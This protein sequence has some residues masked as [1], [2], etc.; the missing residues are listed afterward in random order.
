[1]LRY[2]SLF[3]SS[4]GNSTYIGT[5]NG[6]ILIDAGVSA[7]RIDAALRERSIDPS[8]IRA[9]L[10]SHEHSDHVSGVAVLAKRYGWPILASEG[11]LEALVQTDKLSPQHRLFMVQPGQPVTA[12]DLQIVP[13]NVPHDSRQCL[14]FRINADSGHAAAVVTDMGYVSDEIRAMITGCNLVHIESNHDPVMLRN[15]PYPFYLQERILGP[16]GHLSNERC[17]QELPSLLQAGATRFVLAHLSE[18]NNTPSLALQ[19]AE[20]SLSAIGAVNNRDYLLQAAQP[21][22][23]EPIIYF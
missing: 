22:G 1:M 4:R 10:I 14:G 20:K 19:T 17:S 12:G 11:T 7:K 15:G 6:G 13:V 3:S 5:S 8:R 18:H 2:C 16:G 9:L 21:T 23:T